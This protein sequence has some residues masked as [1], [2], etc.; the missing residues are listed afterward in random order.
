MQLV[1][2]LISRLT[3][4]K[5]TPRFRVSLPPQQTLDLL[6]EFYIRE[7]DR[8][9]LKPQ[10]DENTQKNLIAVV[11]ALTSEQPK[12]G[13]WLYGSVGNGKTTMLYAI[14]RL[15]DLLGSNGFFKYMGEYFSP[16]VRFKTATDIVSLRQENKRDFND[17]IEHSIVAIDDVGNEPKEILE[18]GNVITPMVDL[19]M[20]RYKVQA[21]TLITSNLSPSQIKDKY[22]ER[23]ADRCR[24][25][26]AAIKFVNSTYRK[27]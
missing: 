5:T 24:E 14:M 21:F 16:R 1:G 7:V 15:I 25:M 13:I 11:E 23:V 26:F 12:F 3:P 17:F 27:K 18:Y 19:L 8:R 6:T 9:H 10:I 22:D 20:Y 2:Q 4:A